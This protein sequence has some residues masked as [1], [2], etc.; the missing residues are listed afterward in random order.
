[1]LLDPSEGSPGSVY[2]LLFFA[3]RRG[4]DP[5]ARWPI[6]PRVKLER[7]PVEPCKST[8]GPAAVVAF[9]VHGEPG[10]ALAFD[11]EEDAA[12]FWRDFIVRQK[13][14]AVSLRVSQGSSQTEKLRGDVSELRCG[15]RQMMRRAWRWTS[16]C[17]VLC[18]LAV[19][20]RTAVLAQTEQALDAAKV[21]L[22]EAGVVIS[23][24]VQAVSST[25][26][27]V[28]DLL[29]RQGISTSDVERCVA[30]DEM[31]VRHCAARLLSQRGAGF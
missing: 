10:V 2:E 9:S 4:P 21:A 12:S 17:L 1:M 20:A 31:E 30:A 18:A 3:D 14:M 29:G 23:S 5:I 22:G 16:R 25:T 27:V 26:T 19:A 24:S 6:G 8:A 11:D 15:I 13:L 7:L 28:C